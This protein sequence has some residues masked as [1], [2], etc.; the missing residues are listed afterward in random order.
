VFANLMPRHTNAE[1]APSQSHATERG[2]RDGKLI[3]T[4]KSAKSNG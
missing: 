3:V 4:Y 2:A 1:G